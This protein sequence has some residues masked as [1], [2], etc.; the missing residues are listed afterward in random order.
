MLVLEANARRPGGALRSQELT[1]P[2]FVHDVGAGFFAFADSSP[3][4]RELELSRYGLAFD[5]APIDLCHPALDGSCATL[6][7]GSARGRSQ[8]GDAHD[9][10][11]FERLRDWYTPR[12]P[13][14]LRFLLGVPPG[15]GAALRVGLPALLRLGTLLGRSGR[16]VSRSL[17]RSPSARRLI[18]GLCLHTDIGPDD[19]FGAAPGVML[20]LAAATTGFPVARG[21]AQRITDAL[22]TDLERHGGRLLLGI[23]AER[24]LADRAGRAVAV[25]TATGEELRCREAVFADTAAPTLLLS[26]L[27]P[28]LV[29]AGLRR[30]MARAPLGV[31]VLK[32]DYALAGHVP[33]RA[34]P[35]Q[36]SAVVHVGESVDDLARVKRELDAGRLPENPY[37]VVGQQSLIDESRAPAGNHTLYVY[38]PV[39]IGAGHGPED[40]ARHADAV[41]ARLEGLAPGF[42]AKIRARCVTTPAQLEAENANLL[43]GNLGGGSNQITRQLLLRPAFP[44]FRYRMPV[45]RLYLCSSYA[46]PGPGVHGMCGYNAAEVALRDLE[47]G[48]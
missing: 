35:A 21:G 30:A 32:L 24:I 19:L 33:W 17:F 31:G 45:K 44:W 6:V 28:A 46:H 2:G 15:V 27:E 36:R 14:I 12:A 20:A 37:L 34:E 16:G 11:A 1:E 5:H 41:D 26:L 42:R 39:P 40:W 29:P 48:R 10:A 7:R 3:A 23:R 4:F 8:L 38:T 25:R 47:R 22:V 43:S 13:A 9:D 18:P